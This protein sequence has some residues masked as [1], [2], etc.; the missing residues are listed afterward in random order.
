[1]GPRNGRLRDGGR[2]L[3]TDQRNGVEVP[4]GEMLEHDP[5]VAELFDLLQ[6]LDCLVDGSDRA[7]LAIAQE[8]V[9]RIAAEARS[10]SAGGLVDLTLVTAENAWRH[11]RVA[12]CR[13]IAAPLLAGC[14]ESLLAL[15][16][17]VERSEE[18]VVFVRE[19]DGRSRRSRLRAAADE[20]RQVR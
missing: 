15:P 4:V 6:M 20:D 1:M 8:H 5:L 19:A 12:E 14:V 9:L 7:A 11:E 13:R 18:R 3:A 17:L 2:E 10:D 16:H